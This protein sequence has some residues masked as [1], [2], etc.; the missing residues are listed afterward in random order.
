MLAQRGSLA[1]FGRDRLGAKSLLRVGEV[2]KHGVQAE[3]E[4]EA[5]VEVEVEVESQVQAHHLVPR[6]CRGTQ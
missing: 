4:A 6:L 2:E 5:E 1:N 3:A